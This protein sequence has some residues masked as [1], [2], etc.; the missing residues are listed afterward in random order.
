MKI[1]LEIPFI[2]MHGTGNDYIYLNGFEYDISS[3]N[4]K[5]LAV[6]ISHRH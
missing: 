2:K 4:L 5:D 3:L 6:K 1:M